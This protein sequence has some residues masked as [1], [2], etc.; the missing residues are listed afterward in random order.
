MKSAVS[1]HLVLVINNNTKTNLR[2][3]KWITNIFLVLLLLMSNC[4]YAQSQV[5]E[6]NENKKN[7]TSAVNVLVVLSSQQSD[8]DSANHY[9]QQ[10]LQ[11]SRSLGYRR[12]EANSLFALA[13]IYGNRDNYNASIQYALNALGIYRDQKDLTGIASTQLLLQASY[14][15]AGDYRNSLMFALSGE[16]LAESNNLIGDMDFTGHRLAPLYLAEI[17]QT[18]ILNNQLDS[19][20]FYTR[21]SITQNELFNGV[22][23]G[24]PVYLL[25]TILQMQGQYDLALK[26]YRLSVPLSIQNGAII[27]ND[28]VQIYSGMSTLFKKNG[29][30]DSSIHYAS[31]VARSWDPEK[32][33]I[34]NLLEAI[35]NLAQVYKVRGNNDSAL[36]YTELSLSLKDS[37]FSREKIRELQNITFNQQLKQQEIEAAKTEFK[38]RLRVYFL[39]G[40]LAIL[41]FIAFLLWRNNRLKQKQ[42]IVLENQKKETEFQKAKVEKAMV[43]LKSTQSLLIQREKMASLG[44]LTAGIAHEIQNPL[45]FVNNFSEVNTELLAEMNQ[46]INKGNFHEVKAI[47]NDIIENEKKINHHGKRADVIVKGMLQHSRSS[48]S[49]KEPTDINELVDEYLRLSYHGLRAKDKSVHAG[50]AGFNA[51]L[52][53][54]FGQNIDKVN[55]ISQD[56]GRVLLNLFTNSF[57]SVDQKNSAFAKAS[58]DKVAG[59][60][61]PTVWVS[62]RQQG[63]KVVIKIK[64]NGMGIPEKIL[65]KIFQPFYT[66]K[67][68]GQGTGLGL[69]LSYDII[70]AHGGEIKVDTKEDE[71]AE[72]TIQLPV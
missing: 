71:F 10:A 36:K 65:D 16:K 31:I 15:E 67:P 27:A 68:T 19:A 18:Y 2:I 23:W 24:F 38:N 39:A 64:D 59:S 4:V 47:A 49:E 51:T 46:E 56:I 55:I 60:Y 12:G 32:S 63:D 53:T 42:Y 5:T 66:T 29:E 35:N 57:Y 7:D 22:K 70:K 44:E 69:S 26:N 30:L 45:N 40:G 8:F 9:A 37:I 17:G 21:K 58:E 54:D 13:R 34:K 1:Y 33:E 14:R 11:I 28:T 48:A 72:F 61:E 20:L 6:K 25:A 3:C 50:Q 41:L 62:T 52:K 43:D